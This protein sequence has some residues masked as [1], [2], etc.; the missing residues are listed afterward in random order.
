MKQRSSQPSAT[1]P[2]VSKAERTQP[3]PIAFVLT[4]SFVATLAIQLLNTLTGVILARAFIPSAR[5]ELAALLLWPNVIGVVATVGLFEAA[6]YHTA[7]R[8]APLGSILGS[9]LVLALT[10]AF[11]FTCIAAGLLP[12]ALHHYSSHVLAT[13]Y[14]YLPYI[15]MTVVSLM[16][17][18]VVNGL[19]RERAFHVMRV[20]VIAVAAVLLGILAIIHRLTF[21]SAVVSYLIAQVVTVALSVFLARVHSTRLRVDSRLIRRMFRYGVLSHSGSISSQLNQRLDLLV[22]SLFL[23]ARALGLYTVASALTSL[24]YILGISVAY[25]ILPRVAAAPERARQIVLARRATVITFW[26]S[27]AVAAPALALTPAIVRLLFGARYGA[28]S[29][30]AQI[31]IVAGVGLGAARTLEGILRGL[32]RPFQAGLSEIIALAV[33]VAGLA[34]LL[35]SLGI[36]GAAITS[37]LAYGTSMVLMAVLTGRALQVNAFSLFKPTRDDRVAIF[38][39]TKRLAGLLLRPAWPGH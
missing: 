37:L 5:G 30:V 26:V 9:G 27:C 3:S 28:A 18:G 39:A 31:L 15:P 16:L 14:T 2:G 17:L 7:S 10:Q 25:V 1:D 12:L 21:E 20:V 8:A 13:A 4:G 23:S 24:S 29:G 34:V 36:T 19:H 38:H 35:P 32:R 11:L 22:I 6:T 33:T